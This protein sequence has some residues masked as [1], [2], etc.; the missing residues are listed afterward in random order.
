MRK[1]GKILG[2][3]T[4]IFLLALSPVFSQNAIETLQKA[5][6]DF[7]E[8]IARSLPFNSTMGLNWSDA[9]IGKLFP[10]LPPHFGVGI[11]AGMTTM[12][13]GSINGLASMFGFNLPIDIPIGFPLPGYTIEARVGG[14]ILPFDVG[15][16]FGTLGDAFGTS[17]IP[18][19]SGLGVS[20]DMKYTLFG[21][22]IR[23]A[24]IDSKILPIKLSVGFGINRLEGGITTS[25]GGGQS[26]SFPNPSGGN[27]TLDVPA[28]NLALVWETTCFELKAHVSFP[29]FIITPYAG[30]G[31]SYA[32]SS[33]GYRITSDITVNGDPIN[34]DQLES[35]NGFGVSVDPN[36]FHSIIEVD[37]F[38]LRLYG[39]ISLNLAMFKLDLTGMYNVFDNGLGFTIGFRFQL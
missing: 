26:F 8:T 11:S 39:G 10:S 6:D 14:I 23:Y 2:L 12:N 29:I 15:V 28:P 38:N 33:A 36:G 27:W 34:E 7:S 16:K 30:A 18:F 24:V 32:K 21:A 22:D 5:A 17:S 19:I 3:F 4:I 37:G 1:T 13:I 25:I 31:L 20:M 35:L 9:Y